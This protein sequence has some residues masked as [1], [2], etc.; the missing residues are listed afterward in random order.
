MNAIIPFVASLL[1]CSFAC[2]LSAGTP[3]IRIS[4]KVAAADESDWMAAV[5]NADMANALSDEFRKLDG[6]SVTDAQPTLNITCVVMDTTT[7][8]NGEVG[9]E[10]AVTVADA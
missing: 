3:E 9:F 4:V 5:V 1:I 7:L 8:N 2:N 10:A 6:V